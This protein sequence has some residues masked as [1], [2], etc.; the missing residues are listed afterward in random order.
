MAAIEGA[1][2]IKRFGKYVLAVGSLCG[3]VLWVIAEATGKTKV[4]P[5]EQ[6]VA[7]MFLPLFFGGVVWIFGWI[8]EGF[9][10]P[11]R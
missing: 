3:I 5:F 8:L 6:L 10:K 9:L 1:K 2:R 4:G 7:F 11:A